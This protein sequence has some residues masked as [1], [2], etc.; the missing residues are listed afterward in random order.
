MLDF[1]YLISLYQ[2]D[3]VSVNN[4]IILQPVDSITYLDKKPPCNALYS[5][6][7]CLILG[8]WL[9]V[10]KYFVDFILKCS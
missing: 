1:R 2:W 3:K 8:L 9:N 7:E 5:V 6:Y 10:R 4:K